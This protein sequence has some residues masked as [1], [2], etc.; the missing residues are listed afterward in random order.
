[1][2]ELLLT[3]GACYAMAKLAEEDDKSGFLWGA[4]TLGLCLACMAIV[5]WPFLRILLATVAAFII[6]ASTNK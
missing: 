2:F 6:M 3:G 1:M 5:P 4:V